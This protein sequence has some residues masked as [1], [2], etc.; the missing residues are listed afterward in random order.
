MH[1]PLVAALLAGLLLLPGQAVRA[2]DSAPDPCAAY[3]AQAALPA[4]LQSYQYSPQGYGGQGFAPLTYPFSVGPY[5][6]AA[7]FGGRGVPFGSAPA[8]GPLA[9]GLTANNIFTQV[10]QPAG[11]ALNQ[12]ANFGTLVG[13]AGLQ[14][15]ELGTLNGRYGNSALYQTASATYA[16]NYAAEAGATFTR[17]LAECTAQQQP[18]T[19]S[20]SSTTPSTV[21]PS[22]ATTP[23]GGS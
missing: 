8:F 21:A 2:D 17:A 22:P 7:F 18:S 12:P 3:A 10:I 14:Q 11:L 15:G 13:L 23:P 16:Q 4:L 19:S 9:P 5:G 20:A 1:R 6:T